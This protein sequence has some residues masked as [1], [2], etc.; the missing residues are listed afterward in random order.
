MVAHEFK[1]SVI[2]YILLLF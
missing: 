2:N 1:V